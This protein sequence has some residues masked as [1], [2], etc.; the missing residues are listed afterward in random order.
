MHACCL[1]LLGLTQLGHALAAAAAGAVGINMLAVG[2]AMCCSMCT[3]AAAAAA[4]FVTAAGC[5]SGDGGV[6]LEWLPGPKRKT[7]VPQR[8]DA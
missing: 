6:Q 3:D 7:H 4:A 8:G 5:R 1:L 2:H